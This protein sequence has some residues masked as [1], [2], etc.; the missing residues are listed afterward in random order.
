MKQDGVSVKVRCVGAGDHVYNVGRAVVFGS[1]DSLQGLE[2]KYPTWRASS[3]FFDDLNVPELLSFWDLVRS[4]D[5][6]PGQDSSLAKGLGDHLVVGWGVFELVVD[7]FDERN[8]G[9]NFPGLGVGP[10]ADVHAAQLDILAFVDI[11]GE[12]Y[13]IRLT[14]VERAARACHRG[15]V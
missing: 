2:K 7:K 8:H 5:V 3:F 14:V 6:F 13:R 9:D 10:E 15:C 11:V 12:A 1:L 4:F